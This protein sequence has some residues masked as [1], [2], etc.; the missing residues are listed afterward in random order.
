MADEKKTP[1]DDLAQ[2][3]CP[4]GEKGK[5]VLTDMNEHHRE[6]TSWGL[7]Q[8]RSFTGLK[9]RDALDIG[10]GG[11]NTL[12]MLCAGYPRAKCIGID[13]SQTAV[14]LTL[15]RNGLYHR[16]G[17]L[18][19]MVADVGSIPFPDE[20]FDVITAVETY[21][22]WPDLE[23]DIKLAASK[24]RKGGVM[25]IIA[26]AYYEKDISE[27]DGVEGKEWARKVHL[28]SNPEM[29]SMMEAAGLEAKAVTNADKHW[30][31]FVGRK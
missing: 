19:A 3:R 10:C 6:L 24:L 8:L 18:D 12:R 21:F 27:L 9:V 2:C 25:L 14:D 23:N 15:E 31:V 30:V 26:E 1:D 16:L 13:I 7:T 20:S 29:V 28:V 22:F 11:G 4:Q 17:N 5:K